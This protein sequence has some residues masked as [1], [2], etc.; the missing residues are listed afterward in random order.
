MGN[1]RSILREM[2]SV[3]RPLGGLAL[4]A[5]AA[6]PAQ[7][8]AASDNGPW[9]AALSSAFV[10]VDLSTGDLDGDGK[11][12]TVVC[13]REDTGRTQQV[14]GVAV[15]SGRAPDLRPVFHV[16]LDEILCEKARVSGKKL[17]VLLSDKKQL[18]WSPGEDIKLRGDKGSVYAGI[19]AKA[20]SAAPGSAADRAIDGDLG[21]AWAEGAPGT[22][23]GQ[24][25]TL[26]LQKPTDVGYVAIHSGSGAGSRAFFD[27]NR[28]HRGSLRAK[29]EADVG[30]TAAGIDFSSLGIE[31]IGDR[32][33]F[34]CE[35]KPQ[36][37]YVPVNRKGVVELQVRVESVYLGD[38]KDDTTIAEIEVVPLLGLS[39]TVDR[40]RAAKPKDT[41]APGAK[42]PDKAKAEANPAGDDALKKLDESG[43]GLVSDDGL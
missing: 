30:D 36:V 23:I 38:K 18:I 15:F 25:L 17:G 37:L 2:R 40:A 21:T 19:V 1:E 41:P 4:A 14:S 5:V 8:V 7:A 9:V 11:D 6:G 20:S 33:E 31:A 3:L 43:R 42:A 34:N 27:A 35:N 28:I 32:I 10:V 24:T 39:E 22:G 26:T 16:Q 29:T 12:E 13:Y